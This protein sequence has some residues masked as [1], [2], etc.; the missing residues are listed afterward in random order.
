MTRPGREGTR[1]RVRGRQL[2]RPVKIAVAGALT[3]TMAG[4][5]TAGVALASAS[6]PVSN[7]VIRGCYKTSTGALSVLTSSRKHRCA[8]GSKSLDWYQSGARDAGAVKSVGQAGGGAPAFYTEGRVGWRA[9]R[10][11]GTGEYC[12]TPDAS[13]TQANTSLILNPGSPGGGSL[14]IVGW[15]GYCSGVNGRLGLTVDTFSI[16]GTLDNNIPFEAVIP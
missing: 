16:G 14:G 6:G 8:K 7:G 13:S 5:L 4:L 12:L 10:S 9:V 3:I 15:G 11:I 2:S 1:W